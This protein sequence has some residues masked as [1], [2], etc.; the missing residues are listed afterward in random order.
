MFGLSLLGLAQSRD[1]EPAPVSSFAPAFLELGEKAFGDDEKL[2]VLPTG[3]EAITI[4]LP[5]RTGYVAPSPDGRAL[6]AVRFFDPPQSR[7]KAGLYKIEFGP[8]RASP[9]AGSGG[10]FSI[11]GIRSLAN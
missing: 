1:G 7:S 10:L 11:Y 4:P 5:F 9:V 6:Y 3:A 2:I 8:A